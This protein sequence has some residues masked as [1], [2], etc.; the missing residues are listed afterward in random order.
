MTDPALVAY[1]AEIEALKADIEGMKA[2]NISREARGEALA[3]D[4]YAFSARADALRDIST[5]IGQLYSH[6]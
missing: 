4:E 5:A 2:T 6:R 1:T 3:Y